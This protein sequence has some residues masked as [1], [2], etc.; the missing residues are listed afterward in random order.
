MYSLEEFALVHHMVPAGV[1]V[2]AVALNFV[3][4]QFKGP[5]GFKTITSPL[6][7]VNIHVS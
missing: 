1:V 6:G 2:V 7:S 4:V 3:P 5:L